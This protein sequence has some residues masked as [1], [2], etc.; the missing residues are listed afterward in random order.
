MWKCG[1]ARGMADRELDDDWDSRPFEVLPEHAFDLRCIRG[2]P[3]GETT[4]HDPGNGV[5]NP[6]Q[7]E[8]GERPIDAIGS[9][10]HIFDKEDSPLRLDRIRCS[11]R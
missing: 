8:L 6:R 11:E 9:L 10:V 3:A 5:E 4:G 1:V 2:I 7:P